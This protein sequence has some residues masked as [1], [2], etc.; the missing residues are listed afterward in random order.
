VN[1]PLFEAAMTLVLVMTAGVLLGFYFRGRSVVAGEAVAVCTL[2]V[3]VNLVFD[4]P[5]FS[6]GPMKMTAAKYYSEIGV[7]YLIFPVFALAA[8]KMAPKDGRG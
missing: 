7:D 6:Y 4:Y 3:A 2:W 8:S 1:A 5:M